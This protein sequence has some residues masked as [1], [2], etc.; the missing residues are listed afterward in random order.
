MIALLYAAQVSLIL[1]EPVLSSKNLAT[2]LAA[3]GVQPTDVIVINGEYEAGSTLN[4]Y[5]QHQ[6]RILNGRSAN[7][8]YGSFFPD[9]P[10][11][12][13][14]DRTF[15]ALWNSPQRVFL[16]AEEDKIPFLIKE[17]YEVIAHSGGKLLLSNQ[18]LTE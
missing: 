8:W 10:Q 16:W 9:A 11:I 14:D 2:A 5:L 4:F 13:Y 6:V 18:K 12:F 15:P 3:K 7:L 1:F 17:K